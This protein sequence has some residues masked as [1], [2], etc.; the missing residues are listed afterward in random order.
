MYDGIDERGNGFAK[1]TLHVN[2]E[3]ESNVEE[4]ID[5]LQGK[6]TMTTPYK[7]VLWPAYI[8]KKKAIQIKTNNLSSGGTV[9]LGISVNDSISL[10]ID[11]DISKKRKVLVGYEYPIR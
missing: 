4:S 10:E 7:G 5:R 1:S 9:P 6:K 8:G 11:S 3:N 2:L